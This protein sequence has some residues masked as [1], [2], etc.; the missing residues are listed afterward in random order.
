MRPEIPESHLYNFMIGTLR[1]IEV[2]PGN[3]GIFI[4]DINNSEKSQ[5]GSNVVDNS[6]QMLTIVSE[7]NGNVHL[8]KKWEFRSICIWK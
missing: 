4:R 6:W 3:Y 8:Y 2:S 5:F 1:D 7:G